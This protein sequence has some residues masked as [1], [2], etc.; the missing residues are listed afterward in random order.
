MRG[1]RKR[2]R[3]KPVLKLMS[4]QLLTIRAR[5][6]ESTAGR[7]VCPPGWFIES[8]EKCSTPEAR[9]D[10]QEY[11][12]QDDGT[13]TNWFQLARGLIRA[14]RARTVGIVGIAQKEA[15]LV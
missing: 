6:L 15:G 9:R 5:R 12:S 14:M 4:R 10:E 3:Q 7:I 8:C 2:Q 11:E 13:I 1:G